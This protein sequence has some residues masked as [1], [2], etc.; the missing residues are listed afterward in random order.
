[1]RRL[2]TR[3]MVMLGILGAGGLLYVWYASQQAVSELGGTGS[4]ESSEVGL[5]AGA[6]RVELALLS[7]IGEHYNPQGRDLFKY[8]KKP[9]TAAELAEAER[10]RLEAERL[11]RLRAEAEAAR[12]AELLAQQ[13]QQQSRPTPPP[14][15][16]GPRPPR[17]LFKYIGYLG[18]KTDRIAV[19]SDGEEVLLARAGETV[20]DDFRV[21]EIGFESVVMGFTDPR[22][23][24]DT[25]E[26]AVQ[27][28]QRR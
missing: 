14:V 24:D 26:L 13:Q 15:E 3:E 11:A 18:P 17:I 10:R 25:E 7:T 5:A 16:R 23:E 22:F 12:A 27:A 19:F 21:V 2:T 9:P 20:Q 28:G 6:P 8:S 1:M 4:G